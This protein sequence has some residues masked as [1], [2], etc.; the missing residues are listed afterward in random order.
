M[1]KQ[2]LL[3][4]MTLLPMM[5]SIKAYAHDFEVRNSDH[6]AIY[7]IK[8]SDNM[9]VSVSYRGSSSEDYCYEYSGDIVIPESVTYDGKTYSVTGIGNRAFEFCSGLSSITIPNSVTSI[10][11]NAFQNCSSLGSVTIGNSVTSIGNYAFYRSGLTTITIPNSVTSIGSSA[12]S[13]CD[14]LTSVTTGCGVKN[15]GDHAFAYCTGL[16]DFY[17]HAETMPTTNSNPFYNSPINEAT[18]HVP[19][20]SVDLYKA[21]EPW[22]NFKT[23][24][25]LNGTTPV[26][27]EKCATPTIQIVDGKLKLSCETEGATFVTS[28]TSDGLSDS[29]LGDEI[30][31][32]GTTTCHVSVYAT[33]EGYENSD[34]ARA[35]V[36]LYIGKKGDTNGDGVVNVGDLVTTTNIIMG[37]DE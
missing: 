18:L 9:T 14:G 29:T 27:P 11:F 20:V 34:V 2:L 13:C 3:L 23:I 33:K 1:K 28:Y 21:A 10:G 24:V 31:L 26:Q 5:A 36:E 22:K 8:N 37:K 16:T 7:Y 15:I 35:D 6:V 4:V 25:G 12:F 32:A 19:D 30:V 17:C